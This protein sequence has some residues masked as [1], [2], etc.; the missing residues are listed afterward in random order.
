MDPII[1]AIIIIVFVAIIII[2]IVLFVVV[3]KRKHKHIPSIILENVAKINA[4]RFIRK[5]RKLSKPI[6]KGSG[7]YDNINTDIGNS[8]DEYVKELYDLYSD[9]YDEQMRVDLN[10]KRAE[11]VHK[12]ELIKGEEYDND[13]DED[14][15][16]KYD[17]IHYN[18]VL[19]YLI[20]TEY[21]TDN[22]D[23]LERLVPM[24]KKL[25][26]HVA[27]S[28]SYDY[29]DDEDFTGYG[30]YAPQPYL[31]I[32]YADLDEKQ[33]YKHDKKNLYI[34]IKLVVYEGCVI[35]S[36]DFNENR[37]KYYIQEQIRCALKKETPI[38]VKNQTRVLEILK[39]FKFIFD[40]F[41]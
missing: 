14:D 41:R 28:P 34:G 32:I 38:Y 7:E 10:D 27:S 39:D 26:I 16:D 21:N 30:D 12:R 13:Y 6:K 15:D 11:T 17:N 5:S 36:I 25:G 33:N 24:I 8:S 29:I 40:E 37:K 2:G 3:N 19:N 1:V 35:Y 23:P 9:F 22:P 4:L 20:I 18:N 31:N